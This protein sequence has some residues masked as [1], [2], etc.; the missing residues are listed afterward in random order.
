M[1]AETIA[2]FTMLQLLKVC[3]L[4]ICFVSFFGFKF[5]IHQSGAL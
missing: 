2:E 3:V 5:L 1:E 4:S